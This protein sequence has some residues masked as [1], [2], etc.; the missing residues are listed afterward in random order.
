MK[1]K[2]DQYVKENTQEPTVSRVYITPTL[3]S[4]GEWKEL[5]RKLPGTGFGDDDD[6]HK[7]KH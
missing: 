4:L 6:K 5:T 2:E 3:E 7:Q 1:E